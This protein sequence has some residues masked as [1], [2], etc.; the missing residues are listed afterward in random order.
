MNKAA[1]LGVEIGVAGL[2][3]A[4]PER[5]LFQRGIFIEL[6]LPNRLRAKYVFFI[7]YRHNRHRGRP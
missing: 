5:K 1:C 6:K 2:A 3:A 4:Q 7:T